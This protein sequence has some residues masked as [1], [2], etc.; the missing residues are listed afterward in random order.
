MIRTVELARDHLRTA[1]DSLEAATA[2]AYPKDMI[3]IAEL[4]GY[5]VELIVIGMR[6]AVWHSPGEIM[7]RNTKTGKI[8]TFYDH[9][10]IRI[11]HNPTTHCIARTAGQVLATQMDMRSVTNA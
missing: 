3:V 11:K 8:R 2:A 4:N 7:G 5:K 9:N 6:G 1:Q 10:V